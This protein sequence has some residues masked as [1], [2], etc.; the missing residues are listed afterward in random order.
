MYKNRICEFRTWIGVQD[1]ENGMP[2][3]WEDDIDGHG[4]HSVSTLLRVDPFCKVY[5]AKA[6]QDRD[7]KQGAA[8]EEE[9][10]ER[11]ANVRSMSPRCPASNILI[12]LG[13]QILHPQME[14]RLN[15]PIFRLQRARRVY[16]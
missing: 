11:V 4:T 10:Q 13:D 14:G 5:V 8:M 2:E 1:R 16:Q 9:V 3:T 7:Q 12:V 6:F 15:I